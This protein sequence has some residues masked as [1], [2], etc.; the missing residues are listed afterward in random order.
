MQPNM[1][2]HSPTRYKPL[3]LTPRSSSSRLLFLLTP[4]HNVSCAYRYRLAVLVSQTSHLTCSRRLSRTP[5]TKPE[6]AAY[7][8]AIA[9]TG[10]TFRLAF[11]GFAHEAYTPA[12]ANVNLITANAEQCDL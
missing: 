6:P 7:P 10:M 2:I 8:P 3:R 1:R 4:I 11:R 5:L 12:A 9:V